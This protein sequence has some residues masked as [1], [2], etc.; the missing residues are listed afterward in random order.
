MQVL[1]KEA[2]LPQRRAHPQRQKI[3]QAAREVPRAATKT[4]VDT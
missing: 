4:Q 1:E 2:C 3:W